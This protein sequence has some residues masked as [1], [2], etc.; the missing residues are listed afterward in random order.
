MSP[1][2]TAPSRKQIFSK[3]KKEFGGGK[4]P[5]IQRFVFLGGAQNSSA[6]LGGGA[7]TFQHF[8]S[9]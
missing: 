6:V 3:Y 8:S 9:K 7:C 5:K 4:N 2:A 1:V